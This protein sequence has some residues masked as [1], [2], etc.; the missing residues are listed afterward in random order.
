MDIPKEVFEWMLPLKA[1]DLSDLSSDTRHISTLQ[2][3]CTTH[4][5]NAYKIANLLK[6]MSTKHVTASIE[7]YH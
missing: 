4:F 5:A 3:N 7:Y 6:I 1:I 2:A